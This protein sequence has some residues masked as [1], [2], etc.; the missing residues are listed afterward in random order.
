MSMHCVNCSRYMEDVH[1]MLREMLWGAGDAVGSRKNTGILFHGMLREM[2]WGAGD[3]SEDVFGKRGCF[4]GCYGG[5]CA[6]GG[7]LGRMFWKE[8]MFQMMLWGMLRGRVDVW[9]D[10]LERGDVSEDVDQDEIRT[11]IES[12]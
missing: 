12:A 4:S 8:G 2:F 10:V 5:C 6:E 3:A 9:E 11:I 1:G 7:M